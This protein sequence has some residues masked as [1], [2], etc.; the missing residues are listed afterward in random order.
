MVERGG[1]LLIQ[2][3]RTPVVGGVK[4]RLVPELGEEGACA[5]HI[6][7]VRHTCDQ[8]LA[9]AL[10]PLEIWVAGSAEHP[11]F[12]DCL[13]VGAAALRQQQGADLGERMF[14]ALRDGLDRAERVLLVGSDCPEL[15]PDYLAGALN[16]L[17]GAPVVFGP[18]ADGGYV[19]VGAKAVTEALFTGIAWGESSVLAKT[20]ERA[21][22]LGWRVATLATK[23]DID[24]PEDLQ[25]WRGVATKPAPAT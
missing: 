22:S 10:G 13:A 14:S 21:E 1:A 15:D 19:L 25:R 18:A 23:A 2:F 9:A 16:A 6:E 24:R 8:L 11:V 17:D 3:A 4:T 12:A 20:L 5:L 7:L